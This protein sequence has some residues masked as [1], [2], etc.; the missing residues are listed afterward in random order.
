MDVTLRCC[1]LI[2]RLVNSRN[3]SLYAQQIALLSGSFITTLYTSHI[4]K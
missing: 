4:Y 1:F 3:F 2:K